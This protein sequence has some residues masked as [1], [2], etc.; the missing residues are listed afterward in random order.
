MRSFA[1]DYQIHDYQ[2]KT[3]SSRIQKTNENNWEESL[4]TAS[5][6]ILIFSFSF[7]FFLVSEKVFAN[8]FQFFL[9]V[10]YLIFQQRVANKMDGMADL[11]DALKPMS[12]KS[13]WDATL[14][15]N[16]VQIISN[17]IL[18]KSSKS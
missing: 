15:F 9:C 17:L 13:A 12:P 5:C 18:K 11:A 1:R 14:I 10:I 16:L 4:K 6:V 3:N 2:K 8:V 7:I